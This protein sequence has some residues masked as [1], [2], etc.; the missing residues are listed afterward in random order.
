MSSRSAM[1]FTRCPGC[2][3]DRAKL[4]SEASP[5]LVAL[6]V[7]S[8][9][10]QRYVQRIRL[11][12]RHVRSYHDKWRQVEAGHSVVSGFAVRFINRY[13]GSDRGK[14]KGP[15]VAG[16]GDAPRHICMVRHEARFKVTTRVSVFLL[17]CVLQALKCKLSLHAVR[18][19]K[20]HARLR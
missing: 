9:A 16:R 10:T 20:L 11:S 13:L 2:V 7:L 17:A 15:V 8:Y 12:I 1:P 19:K 3:R 14:H 4:T 6:M 18:S 5:A